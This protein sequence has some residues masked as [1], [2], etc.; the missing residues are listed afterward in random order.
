MN[1]PEVPVPTVVG[2]PR[3]DA[4]AALQAVGLKFREEPS[5]HSASPV[6]T[7]IKTEP[8]AETSVRIGREVRIWVSNGPKIGFVPAL[9]RLSEREA[10]LTIENYGLALGQVTRVHDPV[11]PEG[12]VI[13]Q[14]PRAEIPVPEKTPIDIVIS[15]G[16]EPVA[17]KMPSLKGEHV[18]QALDI[19]GTLKLVEGVITEKASESFPIG[20]VMEQTPGADASVQ[21]GARVDLVISRG[22]VT[23]VKKYSDRF[24]IPV[25]FQGQQQVKIRLFVDA[26]PARWVYWRNHNPGETVSYSVEWVGVSGRIEIYIIGAAGT[27]KYE[28]FLP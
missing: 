8:S 15:K 21:E 5:Q 10:L 19:I 1:P 25:T 23:N 28:R 7:V 26:K 16:P 2:L 13:E 17:L 18:T 14:N 3:H 11:V 12:L 27:E 24:D 22:T 9:I 6:G 4:I 20:S